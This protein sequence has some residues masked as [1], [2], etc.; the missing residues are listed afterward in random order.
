VTVGA[1]YLTAAL[2]QADAAATVLRSAGL[3]LSVQPAEAGV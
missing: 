1:A 3:G 2:V